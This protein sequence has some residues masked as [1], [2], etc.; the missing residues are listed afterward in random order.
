M[1]QIHKDMKIPFW[2][3][4]F[5]E[6][7]RSKLSLIFKTILVIAI[8][9]IYQYMPHLLDYLPVSTT[10]LTIII[11]YFAI[12]TGFSVLRVIVI[13]RYLS[14]NNLPPDHIDNFTLALKRLSSI[15]AHIVFFFVLL[16]LLGIAIGQFFTSISIFAAAIVLLSREY[17]INFFNGLVMLFTDRFSINDY[18]K[19]GEYKGRIRDV[20]FQSVELLTA[21]GEVVYVPNSLML[22]K[23]VANLSKSKNKVIS[24]EYIVGIVTHKQFVDLEKQTQQ[25]FA[26][27]NLKP[28]ISMVKVDKDSCTVR[29]EIPVKQYNFALEQEARKILIQV[30]LAFRNKQLKT[31]KEK[32]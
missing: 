27:K 30:I 20:T 12:T 13:R 19:V 28:V 9:A 7:I 23:E 8:L 6:R 5:A 22:Q 14:R 4:A 32:K 1:K 29:V 21:S 17:I 24:E 11:H 15:T 26:D 18:V 2:K 10:L 16:S 3:V 31:T 25:A